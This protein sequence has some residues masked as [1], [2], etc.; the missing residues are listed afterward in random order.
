M[1]NIFY[2][3]SFT[4]FRS[5]FIR[6]GAWGLHTAINLSSCNR[7]IIRSKEKIS[8]YSKEICNLIK[9]KRFGEPTIVHFGQDEK[10]SG[11]SLVQLIETSAITG[12]FSENSDSAFIDV[13][14]CADYNPLDAEKFTVDFFRAQHYKS[15]VM[16]RTTKDSNF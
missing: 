8:Q 7:D 13:F 16:F 2:L 12:H 4:N 3:S 5:A 6:S 9:M 11:Y 1:S 10:V 14:S 15:Y